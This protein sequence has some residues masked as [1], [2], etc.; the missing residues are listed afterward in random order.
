[1]DVPQRQ[2][3]KPIEI[4][5]REENEGGKKGG[6][7]KEGKTGESWTIGVIESHRVVENHGES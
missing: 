1:M 4:H 5:Y 2:L 6:E 3:R 7:E